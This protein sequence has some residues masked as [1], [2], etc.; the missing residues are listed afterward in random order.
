MASGESFEENIAWEGGDG[1]YLYNFLLHISSP[2]SN[3]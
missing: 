3:P 1:A 2:Q